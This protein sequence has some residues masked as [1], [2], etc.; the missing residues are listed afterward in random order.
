MGY[1]G[2]VYSVPHNQGVLT[3][4]SEGDIEAFNR[5][6]VLHCLANLIGPTPTGCSRPPA[7]APRYAR[8]RAR[9]SPTHDWT[10]ETEDTPD[11]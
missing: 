5:H 1:D 11:T 3:V 6:Q 2:D 10:L 7:T 8:S 4:R 9:T